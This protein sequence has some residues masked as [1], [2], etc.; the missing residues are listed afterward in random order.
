M[1]DK[2]QSMLV[3]AVYRKAT[4]TD[5]YLNRLSCHP[6]SVFK[7]LERSLNTRAMRL[8]SE[9]TLESEQNH[10]SDV[11][12]NNGYSGEEMKKWSDNQ[13]SRDRVSPVSSIP[14]VPGVGERIRSILASQDISIALRPTRTLRSLLV[15]KRPSPAITLGSVYRIPCSDSNCKFSYVGESGR[16]LGERKKE[17]KRSLQTLDVDRSELAKH[18]C[19]TGH[20]VDLDRMECIDKEQNWRRRVTKEALWTRK[21]KACNK[22]KADIGSFYD[23]LL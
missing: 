15:R 12:Q 21:Y 18:L 10:L 6:I 2:S 4:H 23:S 11:L 14:Y 19:E 17:H 9:S 8:C 20:A 16:P 5:T 1:T 22:T 13:A 7:G 3:F